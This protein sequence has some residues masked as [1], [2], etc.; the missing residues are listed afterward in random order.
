[1]RRRRRTLPHPRRDEPPR[2]DK[3]HPEQEAYKTLQ[4]LFLYVG[5]L[6]VGGQMFFLLEFTSRGHLHSVKPYVAMAIAIPLVFAILSQASRYRWAATYAAAVY[7][8]FCH[9]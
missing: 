9:R 3:L 1:M 4:R 2:I 5:G 6:I 8:I 7:T